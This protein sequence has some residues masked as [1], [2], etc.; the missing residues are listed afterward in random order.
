M[1]RGREREVGCG[2]RLGGVAERKAPEGR[3]SCCGLEGD[4]VVT[5]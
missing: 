2:S 4:V 1:T 3:H 5:E